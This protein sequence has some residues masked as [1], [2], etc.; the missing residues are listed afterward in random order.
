[1]PSPLISPNL[2]VILIHYPLAMLIAGTLIE[3]FSFLWRRSSFRV[4]GRWMILLGALSTVPA[5]FSGIYALRDISGISV[6]TDTRWTDLKTTSPVF[7]NPQVWQILHHH[8]LIQ[9]IAT[10]LSVL[11]VLVWLGASD[12]MRKLLYV[13]LMML[14]LVAV[15]M[16]IR[17]AWF[18]GESVY[19]KGVGVQAV[20]APSPQLTSEPSTQAASQP[21]TTQAAA[22]SLLTSPPISLPDPAPAPAPASGP[23]SWINTPT[24][25][26]QLFPPLELHTIMA[27]IFTSIALVSVALS[28]RRLNQMD[29]SED[30]PLVTG[31]PATAVR[32]PRTPP[33]AFEMGRAFNP[34]LEAEIR[35]LAPA[36]RFW[37]LA[38]VLA[39]FTL[40]GGLFVIARGGDV[41][42]QMHGN[43]KLL[44]HLLWEQI[45]P[46]AGQKLSRLF[47]HAID[48]SLIVILPIILGLLTRF[49]PREKII[50]TIT[51]FFLIA[52]VAFQ[53][54]LG[55]LLLFDTSDGPV[56]KFNPPASMDTRP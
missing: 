18:G 13:T 52:A 38:F 30:V 8:L 51:T 39:L 4:A 5:T 10:G 46:E 3:L 22:T 53:V 42:S 55:V 31:D 6:D 50:F 35:Q 23:S 2:H 11:V 17:G 45:K 7:S 44:P 34:N 29:P 9:S 15:A 32:G 12:R 37:S 41:F 21:A 14:L 16:V 19:R 56:L 26:E 20:L 27:G 47:L 33:S 28:F 36:G 24:R 1:M 25:V 43:P 49:A 40:L 48:G 54:W